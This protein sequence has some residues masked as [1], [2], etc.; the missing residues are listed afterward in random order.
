LPAV[1]RQ[2]H[3][4]FSHLHPHVPG[5]KESIMNEK[6]Q[7]LKAT[8]TELEEELSELDSLD[9][10][11]REMLEEAAREIDDTLDQYDSSESL[12]E[13]PQLL[14]EEDDIQQSPRSRLKEAVGQFETSHPTLSGLL[15]R[16]ID[17]LGQ[18]G[19]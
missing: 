14:E 5:T 16:L 17:A 8:L 9:D 19:I 13:T 1:S 11:T 3:V 12:A 2:L 15:N 10:T 6:L 18:M 4:G 7:R